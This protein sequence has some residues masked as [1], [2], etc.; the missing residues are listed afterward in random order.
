MVG[1]QV[2]GSA[3]SQ[4]AKLFIMDAFHIS[5]QISMNSPIFFTNFLEVY[6]YFHAPLPHIGGEKGITEHIFLGVY[7]S[8]CPGIH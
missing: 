3:F 7:G 1:Q 4:P 2:G 6:S 8:E 5:G